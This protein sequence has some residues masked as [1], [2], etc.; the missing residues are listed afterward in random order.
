MV[1]GV[2]VGRIDSS[3]AG[4][5]GVATEVLLIKDVAY[6]HGVART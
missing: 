1:T 4:I 3:G 5:V 2:A 6:N